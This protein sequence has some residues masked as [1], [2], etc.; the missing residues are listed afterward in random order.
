M[1][2]NQVINMV[3]TSF[4]NDCAVINGNCVGSFD[5][6]KRRD[7]VLKTSTGEYELYL[8]SDVSIKV[9]NGNVL[10][11]NLNS[12]NGDSVELIFKG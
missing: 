9:D 8:D 2:L 7:L 10:I 4:T 11:F 5:L 6:L 1:K 12:I 3:P